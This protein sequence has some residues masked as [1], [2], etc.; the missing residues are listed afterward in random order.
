MGP[1]RE[2]GGGPSQ[3][4]KPGGYGEGKQ[5][6]SRNYFLESRV[7]HFR[8]FG[9]DNRLYHQSIGAGAQTDCDAAERLVTSDCSPLQHIGKT[10]PIFTIERGS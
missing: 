10:L 8:G 6:N 3:G 4:R 1:I 5:P 9:R 7:N 2:A